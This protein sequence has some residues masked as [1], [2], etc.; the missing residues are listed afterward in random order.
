MYEASQAGRVKRTAKWAALLLALVFLH[1][2]GSGASTQSNDPPVN[3]PPPPP[4]PPSGETSGLDTRPSNT[5]CLAW[6]RPSAADTISLTRYTNLTFNQPVAMLQAPNDSSRWFVVQKE[7]VVRTFPTSNPTTATDFVD[8]SARVNPDGEQGLLGMAFAPNFPTDPRVFLSYVNTTSGRVSRISAFRTLNG[9]ATLD[10][11]TENVLLTVN[12]PTSES[13]HKGGNIAFSPNDGMRLYL[14]LG[15][16]GGGGDAHP[17][18]GNGQNLG[19]MLGKMLRIDVGTDPMGTTYTIPTDNPFFNNGAAKCPAAG[20]SSPSCPEIF[21][22]GF[23][24][25]WR[26][27]FDRVNGD[28]WVADVGQN[29]WEEVDHVAA[30]RAGVNYEWDLMEGSHSHQG[31][32]KPAFAELFERHRN[33]VYG[34]FRRRLNNAARAEELAQETF[35]VT[36]RGSEQYEPTAR[37]R[38][39]MYAIALK[40]LWTERRKEVREHRLVKLP[41]VDKFETDPATGLWIRGAL[42]QLD[43]DYREVLMLRE[44]EQLSYD[45]IAEVLAVPINTV[46]SRL[47]RARGELKALLESQSAKGVSQ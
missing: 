46:R 6:D 47:S 39:Y 21:A 30:G 14:G 10:P 31:G 18:G 38:T 9:G 25:P 15:D 32:S 27:S 8:I 13:N 23:R 12:Q 33:P 35:I 40:Q 17:N 11:G 4:P 37:F 5:T 36:L 22:W 42:E 44:Y 29:A 7:G 28:L 45:E 24:N 2:C 1:G 20:R 43:P 41:Q 3:P 26:W 34:F 16:G 19:V